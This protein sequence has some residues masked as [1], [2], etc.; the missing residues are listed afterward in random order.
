MNDTLEK[1]RRVTPDRVRAVLNILV[2]A[3]YFYR[4]DNEELFF[5]LRRHRQEFAAFY[6]NWYGWTLVL[7]EK[8]ARVHKNKWYSSRSPMRKRRFSRS[9]TV[10]EFSSS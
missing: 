10:R 6:E 7:D 2:E 4:S 5:F 9:S 3:P 1:L 8:C